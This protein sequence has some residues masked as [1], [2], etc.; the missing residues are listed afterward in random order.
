MDFMPM[1][2]RIVGANMPEDRPIDGVDQLEFLLGKHQYSNREHLIT[3]TGDQLQA[4]RWRQYRYY[5]IEVVPSGFG[6]S[7]H[8]GLA[9]TY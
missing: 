3:F 6:A 1:F 7:R 4:V 8:E 2:A 9:G 5:L